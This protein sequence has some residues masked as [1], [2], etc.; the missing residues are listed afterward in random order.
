MKLTPFKKRALEI[1]RDD[2]GID[3]GSFA[4]KMWPESL[5]HRRVSNQ[6][7]GACRGKASWL[8]GGS[9]VMKLVKMKLVEDRQI[10]GS[11]ARGYWISQLGRYHL[12]EGVE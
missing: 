12:Q 11:Y 4:R 3:A 9:H 8:C 6:G 10:K 7:N 2:P 5:M 1:I